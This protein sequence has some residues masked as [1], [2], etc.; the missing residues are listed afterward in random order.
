[1]LF[2]SFENFVRGA[3]FSHLTDISQ[4]VGLSEATGRLQD[5]LS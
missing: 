4:A 2:G 1:M 3:T 5:M